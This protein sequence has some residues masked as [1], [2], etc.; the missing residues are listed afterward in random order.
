MSA[1]AGLAPE[2]LTVGLQIIGRLHAD[3]AVLAAAAAFETVCAVNA[4]DWRTP[5]P[6]LL[7]HPK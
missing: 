3:A 5:G 7:A 1:A 6:A 4:Q 2:G